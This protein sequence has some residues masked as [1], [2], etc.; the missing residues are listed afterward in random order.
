MERTRDLDDLLIQYEA[1]WWWIGE[2]DNVL[3]GTT[4]RWLGRLGCHLRRLVRHER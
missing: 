3:D 1:I 2:D 4:R